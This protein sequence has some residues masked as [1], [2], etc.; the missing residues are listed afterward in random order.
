[1]SFA[2]EMLLLQ[3]EKSTSL[4]NGALKLFFSRAWAL[5]PYGHDLTHQVPLEG[6]S[7]F[8]ISDKYIQQIQTKYFL[9]ISTTSRWGWV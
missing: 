8:T 5:L 2:D 6:K 1:M 9:D 7:D 3:P 4:L